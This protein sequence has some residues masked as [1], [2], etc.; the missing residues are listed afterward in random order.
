MNQRRSVLFITLA[1]VAH[2]SSRVRVMQ[3][4][5]H[6]ERAGM[7]C[8]VL[9]LWPTAALGLPRY[10]PRRARVSVTYPVRLFRMLRA[11]ARH[12]L[13][14]V[15][16]ALLPIAMQRALAARGRP[17]VFDFVDPVYRTSQSPDRETRKLRLR[18]DHMVDIASGIVTGNPSGY[19]L[20]S[21]RHDEVMNVVGP[22]DTDRYHPA[23]KPSRSEVVIGWIGT[24]ATTR[25]LEVI[26][27]ALRRVADDRPHVR[28]E[29]I[30]ARHAPIGGVPHVSHRWSLKDEV[31]L[32]Q[33]FDIGVMPLPDDEWTRGKGGYKLLQYMAV[34]I[35]SVASPVGINAD[36][37]QPGRNGFLAATEDDWVARLTEL[38]DDNGL[39]RSLGTQARRDA[40]RHYSLAS[41]VPR[42]A[43]F[44]DRIARR[45]TIL[46]VTDR[47]EIGGA[48]GRLIDLAGH[49]DRSRFRPVFCTLSAEGPLVEEL[50]KLG[51]PVHTLGV[52]RGLDYPRAVARA[53]SLVRRFRPA[54]IHGQIRYGSFVAALI[55][56]LQR[57]PVVLSTRTYTTRLGGHPLLDLLTSRLV[58]ETIAV[59]RAAREILTDRERVPPAR[60]SLIEN[61]IDL[62][63]FAAPSAGEVAAAKASLRLDGG[64]II[65]SLGH[66]HPIKGHA[67]LL[68]SMV[69]VRRCF[70]SAKLL[71]VGEGPLSALL[72]ARAAAS[73]L[74]DAI[75]FAGF[76]RD[77]ATLLATM[78]VFVLPSH[79]EGMS[80]ALLEAMAL[81][82][83]VVATDVGG[84]GEVVTA[85]ENGLL[86]PPKDPPALAAAVVRLLSD[87][88]CAAAMGRHAA[89]AVSARF[90]AQRMA[91]EYA[92][93]YERHLADAHN[94]E[95]GIRNTE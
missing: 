79:N 28:I 49:L 55:G 95:C 53:A 90:S 85:G 69:E 81:G 12:D 47:A 83:P 86:V 65:G 21:H 15:N 60:V 94:A 93:V 27:P 36:I 10:V 4:V 45:R 14:Y 9:P 63:D 31:A 80:H 22:V 38:I 16:V 52:R 58:H 7:R 26:A 71:L 5:P 11:A 66:L 1:D 19:E 24:S 84:N 61:G 92:D 48:E 40:E 32:L 68:D 62:R 20:A 33:R 67:D 57:V 78:D 87:P 54:V 51:C 73:G 88:A 6:L 35:P 44:I 76:R 17:I 64:P 91:A 70:P 23:P 37:I 39:R 30:G 89:A 25:Y 74:A 41:H 8:T 59:S 46:Y 13:V 2:A 50:R 75:V 82:R 43:T 34:G 77:V 18:F 56:R 42:M 29:L 72:T 3:Y